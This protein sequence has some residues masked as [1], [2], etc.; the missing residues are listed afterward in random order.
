[1]CG[2][3]GVLDI[4][5]ERPIDPAV[6][7]R[8]NACLAHRGPDDEG[9][10]F[11]PGIG[12]GHRRLAIIDLKSGH[13]P[14]PNE[15]GSII[16]V[17][18]GEIYN[19]KELAADLAARGHI[20]RTQCDTEV[21]VHG[22]EEW[23]E[24]CI[25][26]FR[27]M[28][29]FALWDQNRRTLFA[30]RDRVGEK[31]FYYAETDDGFLVFASEL[32]AV[33]SALPRR[34]DL[35][36]QAVEDYFAFGYVPEPRT[37]F[38][39]VHKLPP[40]S[41]LQVRRKADLPLP[42]TY[43]DLAFHIDGGR[44]NVRID[45][46]LIDLLDEAVRLRMISDVPLGAFLSGGV[47]SSGIVALMAKASA[48]PVRTCTIA[49]DRREFDESHFAARVAER[50]GTDHHCDTLHIDATGLIDRLARFFSEPFADSSAMPTY[51]VSALARRWVTVALSGDGGDEAF[52][53][54]RRHA[55]HL[56]EEQVKGWLP[57]A[58]RRPLFGALARIYPKLDWAPRFL[59]AQ[60]TF[61]A[62]A[63]DAVGGYFRAVTILPTVLRE[64]IYS[65]DL[66]AALAGY[67][68]VEVLRAHAARID[69]PDPLARVQYL[70]FK[71]W[72]PGAMLVKVDRTSMA[73][74]LEV[75]PPLLD[76]KLVEWA[77]T[78]PP[79]QKVVG[80]EGKAVLKRVLEPL[81][82]A[83]ILYRPKQ[84]FSVPLAAWLR[85]GLHSRL[86][87]VLDRSAVTESGLFDVPT[88]RR[89]ADEHRRGR[90]DHGRALWSVLMFDAFLRLDWS[91]T[92]APVAVVQPRQAAAAATSAL[93]S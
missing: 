15:D 75:R 92:A 33:V 52:A 82:P 6:I 37:I 42:Q 69:A 48:T 16:V 10:F 70:D 1:M 50:Y 67:R 68:A 63:T 89:L 87:A 90:R 65:R 84:G 29:A 8:M 24:A 72:L 11:A 51:E 22:W 53:G 86:D 56:R 18:N 47:D 12:L 45:R 78:L 30:A 54:Y 27:G 88:L 23:G 4:R 58:V 83:E 13:Q 35:D 61:E 20:F 17:Y 77:A 66:H 71:T 19:F 64:S 43:W 46:E 49:M 25:E 32:G 9:T 62:L 31:P 57:A 59:R 36:L 5:S 41:R 73:N 55:F 81:L 26:R 34:P 44:S 39:G 93:V 91:A 3:T 40:G 80:V 85:D 60:A 38:K 74:G 14:L 2:L 7:A 79:E 21:I 28:F 76:H